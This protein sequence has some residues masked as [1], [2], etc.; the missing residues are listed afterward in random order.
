LAHV[1]FLEIESNE[2]VGRLSG[3]K[4]WEMDGADPQ[5]ALKIKANKGLDMG[6]GLL[7]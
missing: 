4:P 5:N 3:G 6:A 2:R 1:G 7:I